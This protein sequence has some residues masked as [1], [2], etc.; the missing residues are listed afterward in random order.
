MDGLRSLIGVKNR[1]PSDSYCK[2]Q[3]VFCCREKPTG[4]REIIE[5]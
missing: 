4:D 1:Q 3:A 2:K 5:K